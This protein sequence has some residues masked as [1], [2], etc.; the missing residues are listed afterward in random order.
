MFFDVMP[1]DTSG[2]MIA[3]YS[4]F[5]LITAVYL[6][7]L[8]IRTGNLNRDMETLDSLQ[9]EQESV[10]ATPATR[11]PRVTQAKPAKA[12]PA[13]KKTAKKR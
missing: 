13:R 8:F 4:I 10:R 9:A 3:G 12:K 5:F 7:S 11:K 1:P 6:A 2:Y